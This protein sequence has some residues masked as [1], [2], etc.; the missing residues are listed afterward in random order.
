MTRYLHLR[1]LVLVCGLVAA[2][3]SALL[4]APGSATMVCPQGVKPPSPYCTDVPPI[5][6]TRNAT[7]VRAT[8]A[9][10]N[11]VAGPNVRN[12]DVTQYFFEYGT[13]TAYDSQTNPGTIGSCP[14]GIDPPSPY[15]KVP[16]KRRVS[17]DIYKLTPCTTYHFQL[18]AQNNDGL[19]NGGDNWFT[20]GFSPPLTDLFAPNEVRAGDT[21]RVAF[22]LRYDTDSVTILIATHRKVEE[23]FSLGPLS[24]GWHS[25]TITAPTRKGNYDLVVLANLSCGRQTVAQPLRVGQH[26]HPG[27]GGG[28]H[29]DDRRFRSAA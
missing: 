6:I 23:V 14:P 3:A 20:T 22:R 11:G 2:C 10:L 7:H 17:A 12:G 8:S 5:A 24:A 29:G 9:R 18:V 15:C 1:W 25:E 27:K 13:T 21:F 19:T 26:G 16:K 4:A 28:P